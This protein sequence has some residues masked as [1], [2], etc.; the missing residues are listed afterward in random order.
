MLIYAEDI[1][2]GLYPMLTVTF[3]DGLRLEGETYDDIVN[4]L[5]NSSFSEEDTV[6]EFMQ[7]VGRRA[8]IQ[9]GQ[10]INFTDCESFIKELKRVNIVTEILEH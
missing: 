5:Y 2:K 3:I 10:A 4:Q 9:T 6:E 1:F 7:G 8:Q